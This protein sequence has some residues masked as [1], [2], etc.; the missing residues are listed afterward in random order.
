MIDCLVTTKSTPGVPHKDFL[1]KRIVANKKGTEPS[2]PGGKVE[3]I[4]SKV[5]LLP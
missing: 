2:V 3:I 1:D 4:I 5:L